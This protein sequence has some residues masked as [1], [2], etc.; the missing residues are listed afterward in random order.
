MERFLFCIWFIELYLSF[1][2]LFTSSPFSHSFHTE[3]ANTDPN[4]EV[5]SNS[6]GKEGTENLIK[7]IG[8]VCGVVIVFLICGV[9]ILLVVR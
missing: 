3:Y 9:F 8:I 2:D 1:K 5:T 6:V 4:D 7:I